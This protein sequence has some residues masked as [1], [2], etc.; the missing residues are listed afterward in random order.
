MTDGPSTP[1][2][3]RREPRGR[4][5]TMSALRWSSVPA[6]LAI[7][8]FLLF[9]AAPAQAATSQAATP[10]TPER[11]VTTEL[12][13]S[14]VGRQMRWLT[15][16]STRL[17]LSDAELRAHF[18]K[19]FLSLP[20]ASPA[21]I[22]E[23]LGKVIDASGLRLLGLTAVQPNALA[24]VV[25]ARGT[26]E[27]TVTLAVD[28]A[29]LVEF[30][31]LAGVAPPV[32]L[33][34]PTGPATVGTDVVQ[35]VD[36]DRGGR[37]LMLT[38]WYPAAPGAADRPLA[39]YAGPL[40]SGALGMPDVRVHA[41]SG[42][43]ARRGRLPVV[44][45]SP[46]LGV[47]R[48]M[49]QALAE[50]LASHGYLVIAVDHTGEAPV[51]FADGRMKLPSAVQFKRPIAT[52]A[53]SRLRDMRLILRRLNTMAPGPRADRRRVAAIGHSLGG[54]TAAALMRAEPSVRAGVDMDGSI[55]GSARRRGVSRP[56]LVMTSGGADSTIRSFLEH[57]RGPRLA[58]EFAGFQ[59]MSFSDVP[60]VAPGSVGTT[61]PAR[62][63]AVQRAYLRA[64]L[65]RYLLGRPS[66]LLAGPSRRWPQVT[67]G[68]RRLCCGTAGS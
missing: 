28:R 13:D 39:A 57:S 42:A 50:D 20:G 23:T 31:A 64:F 19:A 27:L 15:E 36:R 54:S 48:V 1:S 33:P 18:T 2:A 62:D 6:L 24:A 35:L 68:Q 14:A 37:R 43:R 17:P 12:P 67:F 45:F 46:G 53:A 44:L 58:L 47:P 41:H 3:R 61:R 63:V 38:R 29:G 11:F 9:G 60:I 30:A 34:R 4:P 5:R 8:V 52:A 56:F 66:R 40:V 65:D 51:E 7:A 10:G 49:Y 16:A 59:H 55:F 25:T 32:A 26:Q 22:N 21:A